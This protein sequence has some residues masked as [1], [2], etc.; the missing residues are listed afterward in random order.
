[1]DNPRVLLAIALSFLVLLIWQAWMEDYGPQP[2]PAEQ[3]TSPESPMLSDSGE[4]LPVAPDDQPP[5]GGEEE[6][7]VQLPAGQRVEVV[8]DM[9]RAVIDTRGGDLREVDLLHYPESREQS[10]QP[11]RLLEE[12]ANQLFIAQSGLRVSKGPEPTHHADFQVDENR[13]EL[14]DNADVLEVP[15]RWSN[16]AG[17]EVTKLYRFR[18]GSYVVEVEQQIQ[19]MGDKDWSARPYHQLQRT[20]LQQ[21]SRFLYTYTGGVLYSPEEKYQ[22]ISFDDMQDEDLSRDVKNGWAAMIQHYFLGAWIPPLEQT[23]RY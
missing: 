5:T 21:Q 12:S 19:N 14:L 20:P 11:F 3:T 15:L 2:E 8:T 10:E 13:F 18:R 16:D 17:V 6:L 23:A 7:A 9:F 4:D 22:K 1:M